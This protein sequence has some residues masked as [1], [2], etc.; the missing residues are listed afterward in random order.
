LK[1]ENSQGDTRFR[2]TDEATTYILGHAVMVDLV[3]A[4]TSLDIDS[5]CGLWPRSPDEM[6]TSIYF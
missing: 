2:F 5:A 4:E 6:L 3:D 1:F